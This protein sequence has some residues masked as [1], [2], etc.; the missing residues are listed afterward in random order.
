MMMTLS[1]DDLEHRGP[2]TSGL[3]EHL[4][5]RCKH[6]NVETASLKGHKSEQP[7]PRAASSGSV[8]CDHQSVSVDV[9]MEVGQ[10]EIA[11]TVDHDL[12]ELAR[13]VAGIVA[14]LVDERPSPLLT[15]HGWNVGSRE[16]VEQRNFNLV[17]DTSSPVH[18]L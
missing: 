3:V 7:G 6:L 12:N 11:S 8:P 16:I 5:W 10:N 9:D 1:K 2:R 13:R 4:R 14:H 17:A 18:Q 15:R